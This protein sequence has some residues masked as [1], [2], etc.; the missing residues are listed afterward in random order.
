MNFFF[1]LNL[2]LTNAKKAKKAEKIGIVGKKIIVKLKYRDS[3]SN[4]FIN[5]LIEKFINKIR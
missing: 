1:V 3:F 2:D 5:L 4:D